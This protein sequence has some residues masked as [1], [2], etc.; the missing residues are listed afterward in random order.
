MQTVPKEEHIHFA[1]VDLAD[2]YWR[3]IVEEESRYNFAYV[4]P[5]PPGA[6]TRLVIPSALQMGWSESPAYFCTATET[7]HDIGQAWIDQS[8]SLL[9]HP[10]EPFTVP[11]VPARHQ[12]SKGPEY[13]MSAVYVDDFL[14]ACVKNC[15]GTL[16]DQTACATLHAIHNIFLPPTSEDPPGT[17][18]PISEKKLLK[19][20]ACWAMIKEVLGYK[21]DGVN[22][23]IKLPDQKLR[24]CS[25]SSARC[26]TRCSARCSASKGSR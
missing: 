26:S 5:G 15:D 20:D 19:G 18:D 11:A 22:L 13:Q 14:A 23:M 16:L 3:M 10:M 24:H 8:T 4:M 6:P 21:L 9:A 2:G 7:A 12:T 25:T 1:K 17:K